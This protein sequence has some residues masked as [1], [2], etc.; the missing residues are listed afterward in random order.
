MKKSSYWAAASAATAPRSSPKEGFRRPA[1]RRR[2][3]RR[4]LPGE[5][6]R[7]AGAL[8]GGRPLGG[9]H[10]RRLGGRQVAGHP[11]LGAHRA[12]D[13]RA[14]HPRRLRDRVR[15]ALH[16]PREVHLRH[17]LERQD[18][19]HVAHLPDHARRGHERG[20]RGQHRR[21]LRLLRSHGRL[22]L[23]RAGVELV[24]AR[25]HV[26]VPRPHRRADQHHARPP[27]PLRPLL[28]ELRRRED[29]DRPQHDLARLVRLLGRRRD[30]RR[31]ASEVRPRH[32]PA[33]LHG[34][35]RRGERRRRRLPARRQ[36][37]R[38]GGQGLGRD[39]HGEDAH[40][41]PAQRL[42]RDGRGPRDP[43]RGRRSRTGPPLDLRL[44]PRGAPPRTR[45]RTGRRAVDQRLEGHQRRLGVVCAREHDAP[46]GVDRRRHRQGQR[47][48]PAAGVR[49]REGPHAGLHGPRQRK[50]RAR[51]YGRR[52]RGDRHR[53]ARR[54]SSR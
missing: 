46:H 52:P 4:P 13:P 17:G 49:P 22:R 15:G 2:T 44:R 6:R 32:A 54:G 24:P 43:R 51:I 10:P 42:Q 11:R 18:D 25:R 8:R 26:C 19:H 16:R 38:D 47:L 35:Q 14:G 28:P 31:R 7:V 34:P 41:G 45:R 37:H 53:L 20:A 23:V 27:R 30:D 21:E 33:P 39:R 5:T 29:A 36:V 1:L 12:Q 50:T 3:H 9:A 40:R 48:R